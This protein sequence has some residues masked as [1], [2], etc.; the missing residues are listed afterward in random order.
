[1]SKRSRTQT[2]SLVTD[3]WYK[4]DLKIMQHK[5]HSI[6]LAGNAKSDYRRRPKHN[7]NIIAF[8]EEG[9]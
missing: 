3:S 8:Y 7:G 4:E 1:M 6:G 5:F 9:A 2:K